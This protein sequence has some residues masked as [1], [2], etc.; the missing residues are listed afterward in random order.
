[1]SSEKDARVKEPIQGNM[2]SEIYDSYK[3]WGRK[4]TLTY[5]DLETWN[6]PVI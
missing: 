2:G 3:F 6:F 4:Q 5:Y 1:M